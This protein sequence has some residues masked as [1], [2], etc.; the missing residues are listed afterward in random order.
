MTKKILAF[1]FLATITLT[2]NA[3]GLSNK[4][5][6]GNG[7]I[8]TEKRT[9][10]NY[11]KVYSS[12]SFDVLLVKGKEGN[13]TIKGEENII[14]LIETFVENNALKIKF[15]KNTNVSTTKKIE[16]T[17]AVESIQGVILSG[18]GKITSNFTLKEELINTTI[19]GSGTIELLLNTSEV[20][21]TISGSGKVSL[22]GDTSE[23][24]AK[25]SGS[26]NVKAYDLKANKAAIKVSG[27]GNVKVNV[28]DSLSAKISGS[29]NIYYY[30]NPRYLNSK[31]SGSGNIIKRS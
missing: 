7:K 15:K 30:G 2:T 12:S 23:L 5:I 1:L 13:I 20:N 24:N 22:E 29:G 14:P 10:S 6:K 18:S 16:I 28:V 27:S 3:Q 26:G 19:S 31:S 9:T 25:I 8:A 21:V 11:N 4:R 17:V